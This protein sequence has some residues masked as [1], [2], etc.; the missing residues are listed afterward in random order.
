M[1]SSIMHVPTILGA[2]SG[3][4]VA[5][6]AFTQRKIMVR[7]RRHNAHLTWKF[8]ALILMVVIITVVLF[9]LFFWLIFAEISAG[10]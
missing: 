2:L 7:R 4:I 1:E 9:G 3:V 6:Q 5:W 10:A 8:I